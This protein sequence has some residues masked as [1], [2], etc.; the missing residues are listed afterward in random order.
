MKKVLVL[1][2]VLMLLTGCT[3]N[4]VADQTKQTTSQ[5]T[6][7][8][9]KPLLDFS[10]CLEV[11]GMISHQ[12][13]DTYSL[14]E[15]EGIVSTQ[16][17][18]YVPAGTTVTSDVPFALYTYTKYNKLDVEKLVAT[19]QNVF[20]TYFVM[21]E[22]GT[23]VL[24]TDSYL[25]A[26]VS[27]KLTDLVLT[28]P[29]GKE[30]EVRV[31]DTKYEAYGK[32]YDRILPKIETVS[33]DTVSYIFITDIHYDAGEFSDIQ[34]GSLRKQVELAVQLAN[35][36]DAI[37]FVVVGGDI[38]SGNRK[39]KQKTYTRVTEALSPLNECKK[40]VLVL[41]GNHDDNTYFAYEEAY[42]E[43][44]SANIVSKKSWNEL[45]LKVYS[46]SAIVHDSQNENSAYYYYD[47]PGK[48]VRAICLDAIDYPQQVD[49]NGNVLV[50]SLELNDEGNSKN[51]RSY[52]GYSARQLRWLI[53]EALTA[54][55][56]W[57]Y[58]FLSH[59]TIETENYGAE[60]KALITAFQN[61]TTYSHTEIGNADFST[62]N[63][64]I[65]VYHYGHQHSNKM[66]LDEDMKLWKILTG[67]ANI[68]LLS[69]NDPSSEGYRTFY[70]E[71]ECCFDVVSITPTTILK[72]GFGCP[73]D[74]TV[75]IPE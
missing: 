29:A 51:G 66:N 1:L 14:F 74:E 68:T 58:V 13:N 71:N 3:T 19:G 39:D 54:E 60:L 36:G 38:T 10:D 46:P 18:L 43:E 63:G 59:M 56:G 4:S 47:L 22:T 8:E 53:D 72:Y 35:E 65:L 67:T 31:I 57:D 45:V 2:L 27:G 32:D 70:T 33:S 30:S 16:H 62:A 26:S 25:R 15:N 7:F 6:A 69:N 9:E 42:D 49:K 64:K 50:S 55:D 21:M 61:R 28:Y 40:P 11:A 24:D 44:M 75:S 34:M 48:K 12:N 23:V 20:N 52:W 17:V 37:D 41:M 73:Q 5:T